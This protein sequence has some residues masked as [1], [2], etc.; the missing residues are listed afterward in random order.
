MVEY[1]CGRADGSAA[2]RLTAALLRT[3]GHTTPAAML[4]HA[5]A[6]TATTWE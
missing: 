6:G 3:A 4:E 5:T 1:E 2:D